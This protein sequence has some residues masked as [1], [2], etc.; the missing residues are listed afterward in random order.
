L[1]CPAHASFLF[2]CV[3]GFMSFQLAQNCDPPSPF[4]VPSRTW[5]TLKDVS[6][7]ITWLELSCT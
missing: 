3:A 5:I 4:V 7:T 1:C 2:L 6:S